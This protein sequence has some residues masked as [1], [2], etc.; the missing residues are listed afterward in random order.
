MKRLAWVTDPHLNFVQREQRAQHYESVA[1]THPDAVL[2]TGD[3]GEAP[4]VCLFLNELDGHLAVPIYFVLGNHDF[5]RGRIDGV[6]QRVSALCQV[7]PNLQWM[8]VAG[9]VALTET[10][11]LLGHDGWGDA[12]LG[13]PWGSQVFL[14]DWA[15]IG[16]F[17]GLELPERI[18]K[19]NALGDEAAAH[20]RTVLPDALARYRELL[21]LTHVPPFREAC[22]HQGGISADDW[23]P[24]FSCK[25]VGDALASVMQAHPDRRM[26]VLCGHTHSPGEA[27][28]LPNLRVLTGGARYG[29]PAVARV[30]EV[31]ESGVIPCPRDEPIRPS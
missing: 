26:T 10:I 7:V 30:L 16:D 19:L 27:Q 15:L 13:D 17:L 9:V 22:W 1:A 21:V 11:G 24:H 4:D 28:I 14:N 20:F 12:R 29:S 8:N 31:S 25:A 5:Y 3:V 2:L 18:A 6:R 23:L